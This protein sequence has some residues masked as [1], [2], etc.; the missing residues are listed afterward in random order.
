MCTWLLYHFHCI[1]LFSYF[2]PFPFL[3]DISY[4]HSI[5]KISCFHVTFIFKKIGRKKKGKTNQRKYPFIFYFSS[6]MFLRVSSVLHLSFQASFP[7][8]SN[9]SYN[10]ENE[11]IHKAIFT[12]TRATIQLIFPDNLLEF[13]CWKLLEI[14]I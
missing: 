3:V 4:F 10:K 5:I 14:K 9:N 1:H 11:R 8:I 12:R 13:S 6:S 7:G 2:F